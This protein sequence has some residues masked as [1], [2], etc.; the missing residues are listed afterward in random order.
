MTTKSHVTIFFE[1]SGQKGKSD[2]VLKLS[3]FLGSGGSVIKTLV[4]K[5]KH[6][7]CQ[8]AAPY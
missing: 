8:E 1:R 5:F 6:R 2:L 7:R 4:M 3:L